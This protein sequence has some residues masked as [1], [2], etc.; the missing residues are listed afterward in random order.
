MEENKTDIG[1]ILAERD[2][3]DAQIH[4]KFTKKITVMF[5]DIK[6]S[7]SVYDTRGDIAGRAMVHR[8]NE[9][10]LPIIKEHNGILIK[11]IGDA[12]MSAYHTPSDSIRTAI[13]IQRRLKI[14]NSDKADREQIHV[15]I[16]MNY[17]DGLVEESDVFGDIVN[18]ASRVEALADGD[19]IF[20]TE[21]LYRAVKN[22][23]EF[24]FRHEKLVEVKGK[25][26]ALRVFRV[27]WHDELVSMGK[28]RKLSSTAE[29][30][31]TLIIEASVVG[32]KLKISGFEKAEGEERTVRHYEEIKYSQDTIR[33][34]TKNIIDLL[35]R[36]NKRGKIGND[37]LIKLK[38]Y[39]R[40]L[41]DALMPLQ[42]KE[43]IAKTVFNHMLI[44]IDDNLVHIPWELLHDGENFLCQRFSLGRAVSTRQRVSAVIRTIGKPLKMQILADARGDL[45]A[46]YTEGVRIKDD[47]ESIDDWLDVSLKT[48]DI[49][50]DYVKAKIRNFD[51][52][53][54]AGHADHNALK[55]E[56]SGWLLKNGKL[57]A[58]NIIAMSGIMPMPALV[59]SNACQTGQTDEWRLDEHYETKI[60]GLANAFLIS[61]VQHYIG[62][63]WEIPDEAG[64]HFA[65]H[66]YRHLLQG[67]SIGEAMRLARQAL[68]DKYGEDM[69]VWASYM[70]Y[71]DPTTK[72]VMPEVELRETKAEE[73]VERETLA[74]ADLRHREDVVQFPG[75]KKQKN[76]FMVA[77][78]VML[79]LAGAAG[80]YMKTRSGEIPEKAANQPQQVMQKETDSK[81]IDELVASL[82]QKY[83][84]NKFD[85]L[86]PGDNWS[87]MP[88][89]LVFM[90]IKADSSRIEKLIGYTSQTLQAGGRI[91]VVE[92]EL[93]NRLLEELKLS[94]SALADQATALRVGR[95]LSARVMVTGSIMPD[96][97]GQ[98][99]M[100]RIIDTE[101]TAVKKVITVESKS[102]ELGKD[103]ADDLSMKILEAIKTEYP[104]RGKV[105]A[106]TGDRYQLNIGQSHGLKK[107]DKL[108]VVTALG[109]SG[110]MYVAVGELEV[111]DAGKDSSLA[112]LASGKGPLALGAK[113]REKSAAR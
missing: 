9:V 83:R 57:S 77:G 54:Y 44:S 64:Y 108:E 6:G 55:P 71:G 103:A 84:E 11:T 45:Q 16:G 34:Y 78:L 7:T 53:H 93:I 68:I 29:R 48:T 61:G 106:V 97:H 76:V 92:R 96:E 28:I 4:A 63:F 89:S 46:A 88:L 75:K 82:S 60:F 69:I 42:I 109:T 23:D 112:S 14:Y 22:N 19:E 8:H 66:F 20:I 38:E 70:L 81:R 30:E 39:G 33:N 40:L 102:K 85:A 58:E 99:V 37:L 36:A 26:D 101:T 35:N 3:L 72:Y 95:V 17:G 18:V 2:K 90:D 62:T 67:S 41:F 94:N 107:G 21:D 31:G 86:K 47:I 49:K 104:L 1:R 87:S 43:R 25:K 51:I 100:L 110:D 24:I 111:V 52:V 59:F 15:R 12:T 10:V 98:I 80:F 27:I 56:D 50:T 32:E 113:V 79:L 13:D 91:N 5:T 73:R 65:I 74:T 105:T